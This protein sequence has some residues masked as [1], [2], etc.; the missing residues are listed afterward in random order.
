MNFLNEKIKKVSDSNI[1]IRK[2]EKIEYQIIQQIKTKEKIKEFLNLKIKDFLNNNIS[3]KIKKKSKNKN[4]NTLKFIFKNEKYKNNQE[5]NNFL[6]MEIKTFYKEI[7]LKLEY[8]NF[9]QSQIKFENNNFNYIQ[10]LKEK[11]K[12]FIEDYDYVQNEKKNYLSK[13]RNN[14]SMFIIDNDQ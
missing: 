8:K 10:K 13:K 1:Q 2:F 6:E 3:T 7:F 5:L 14:N 9:I 12:N 4:E 11:T